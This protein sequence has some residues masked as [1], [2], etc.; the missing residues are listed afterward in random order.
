M[1]ENECRDKKGQEARGQGYVG[2]RPIRK[3]GLG[4]GAGRGGVGKILDETVVIS[5]CGVRPQ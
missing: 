5:Y 4:A 1:T 2:R 3:D